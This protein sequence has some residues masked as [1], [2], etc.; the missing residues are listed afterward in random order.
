MKREKRKPKR[1]KLENYPAHL[2]GLAQNRWGGHQTNNLRTYGGKFGGAGPVKVFTA[3]EIK[4]LE[5]QI[6]GGVK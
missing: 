5:A 1:Q 2:R 4:A 6:R 3:D